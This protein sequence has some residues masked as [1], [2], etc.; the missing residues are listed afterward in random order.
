MLARHIFNTTPQ[1]TIPNTVKNVSNLEVSR[2]RTTFMKILLF[3]NSIA[4]AFPHFTL[5]SQKKKKK[6]TFSLRFC[7]EH[8]T[9]SMLSHYLIVA[10]VHC[11]DHPFRNH[12]KCRFFHVKH[13]HYNVYTN[14]NMEKLSHLPKIGEMDFLLHE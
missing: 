13:T 11:N 5:P 2:M 3:W 9:S 1:H 14:F 10:E 8:Q 12:F 4:M 7:S 6:R